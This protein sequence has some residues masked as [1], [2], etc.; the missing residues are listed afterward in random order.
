MHQFGENL[1]DA[2]RLN[3]QSCDGIVSSF[4][5][6][7]VALEKVDCSHGF[8]EGNTYRLTGSQHLREIIPLFIIRK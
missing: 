5:K 7:G 2:V 6:A 8:L 1:L 3:N 4:M